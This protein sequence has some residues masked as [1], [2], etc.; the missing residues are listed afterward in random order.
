MSSFDRLVGTLTSWAVPDDPDRQAELRDVVSL[1]TDGG[2]R[3]RLREI[4]GI[5]GL[6]LQRRSSAR[7]GGRR[8][9]LREGMTIA[10]VVAFLMGIASASA[11]PSSPLLVVVLLAGALSAAAGSR[12]SV[13]V[14]GAAATVLIAAIGGPTFGVT[15]AIGFAVACSLF[16]QVARP[17]ARCSAKSVTVGL[18]IVATGLTISVLPD[19]FHRILLIVAVA[20]LLIAARFDPKFGVVATVIMLCRFAAVDVGDVIASVAELGQRFTVEDLVLRV[21]VMSAGLVV[22]VIVTHRSFHRATLL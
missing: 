22:S 1:S 17:I 9:S 6:G 5:F 11:G 15:A 10:A 20:G 13:A 3:R 16:G 19:A 18:M 12:P 14:I 21:A 2:T 7:L 4:A 8:A